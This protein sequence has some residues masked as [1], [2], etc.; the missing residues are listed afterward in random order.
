MHHAEIF[1]NLEV[2]RAVMMA[3]CAIYLFFFFLHEIYCFPMKCICAELCPLITI[4]GKAS[5]VS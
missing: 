5:Y 4:L 2:R 3:K 1:I